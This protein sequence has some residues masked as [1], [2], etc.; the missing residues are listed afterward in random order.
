M[1]RFSKPVIAAISGYAVAGGLELSLM[2]DIRIVEESAVF[3]VFCRRFGMRVCSKLAW[4]ILSSFTGVP[5]IDGGTIRLPKLIGLSRAMDMILT[6]RSVDAKTALE[7]GLANQVV[8]TG[9]GKSC[10]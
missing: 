10:K 5:L 3:G 9:T 2:C 4:F 7:W 6:G 1:M 8:A